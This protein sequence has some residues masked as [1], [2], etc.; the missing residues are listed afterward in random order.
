MDKY[1]LSHTGGKREPPG[2]EF[3]LARDLS[4]NMSV[5]VKIF[6]KRTFFF[7]HAGVRDLIRFEVGSLSKLSHPNVVQL[8]DVLAS[9]NKIFLVL[10]TFPGGSSL[11][12]AIA[13][14]G[15]YTASADFP[16]VFLLFCLEAV[17]NRVSV[18][19]P[20]ADVCDGGGARILR[21]A[22]STDPFL[23]TLRA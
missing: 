2:I 5:T 22:V 4:T 23:E 6:D 10:E 8:V 19:F 18:C 11:R 13:V 14:A 16:S 7:K 9:T 15:R 20:R 21:I 1:L 17:Y 12:K 3:R